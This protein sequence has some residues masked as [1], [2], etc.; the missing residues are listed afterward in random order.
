MTEDFNPEDPTL[1]AFH[2]EDEEDNS[3]LS[4]GWRERQLKKRQMKNSFG[5]ELHV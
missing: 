3:S 1:V 5:G 4:V 2:D